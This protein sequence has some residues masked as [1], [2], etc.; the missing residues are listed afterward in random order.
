MLREETLTEIGRREYEEPDGEFLEVIKNT[1]NSL[2]VL[3]RVEP[4]KGGG[5][6]VEPPIEPAGYSVSSLKEELEERDLTE[7]ELQ[8]LIESEKDGKG[9]TTAFSAIESQQ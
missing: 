5:E 7:E 3:T 4:D 6:E 1:R 9:R 8:A 2:I